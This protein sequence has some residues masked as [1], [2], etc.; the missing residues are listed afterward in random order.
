MKGFV[1]SLI[2]EVACGPTLDR[3]K[4]I[5]IMRDASSLCIVLGML[6]GSNTGKRDRVGS[7]FVMLLFPHT[8]VYHRSVLVVLVVRQRRV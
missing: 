2:D 4:V 7:C 5:I 1:C 3:V 6:P 8:V